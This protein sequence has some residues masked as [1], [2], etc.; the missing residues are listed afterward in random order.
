MRIK[1]WPPKIMHRFCGWI[2]SCDVTWLEF[3]RG[4][5][6]VGCSRNDFTHFKEFTCTMILA[7]NYL[8]MYLVRPLG[9]VFCFHDQ[10][11]SCF[12]NSETL[13]LSNM[14][15]FLSFAWPPNRPVARNMRSKGCWSNGPNLSAIVGVIWILDLEPDKKWLTSP[16]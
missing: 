10:T 1:Q 7:P 13:C 3:A 2:I 6:V 16:F 12:F 15:Q 14:F 8:L 4:I 5:S 9:V 11:C